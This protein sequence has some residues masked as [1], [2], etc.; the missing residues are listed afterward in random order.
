MHVKAL[1][2]HIG[3]HFEV[4]VNLVKFTALRKFASFIST[5]L[6]YITKH[7]FNF[8]VCC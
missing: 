3:V 1:E 5:I 6:V 2:Q 7:N 8:S 4:L